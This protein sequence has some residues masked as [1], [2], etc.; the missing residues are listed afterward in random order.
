[1]IYAGLNSLAFETRIGIFGSQH[2]IYQ[3]LFTGIV[4]H[5]LAFRIN[6]RK[7]WPGIALV[8]R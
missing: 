7:D 3:E 6:L 5:N 4:K 2:R 1:M 8:I